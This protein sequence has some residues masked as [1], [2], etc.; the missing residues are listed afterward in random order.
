LRQAGQLDFSEDPIDGAADGAAL[1]Q[2]R[3]V[4]RL[5]QRQH[6]RRRHMMPLQDRERLFVV[7]GVEPGLHQRDQLRF[8]PGAR[9]M[10]DEARV[11]GQV[12][13]PD[14]GTQVAPQMVMRGHHAY[15]PAA[16]LEDR[17][18]ND[19][20]AARGA[21]AALHLAAMQVGGRNFVAVEVGIQQRDI[22]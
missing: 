11:I 13:P 4:D 12:R 2:M 1:A 6:R 16:S 19:R 20:S 10:I 17:H 3:I 21:R 9:R 18:R 7:M 22:E 8:V 5:D 15:V 14:G